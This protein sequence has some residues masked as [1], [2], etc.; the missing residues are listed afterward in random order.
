MFKGIDGPLVL[1]VLDGVGEIKRTIGNAVAL[2]HCPNWDAL[3]QNNRCVTLAAHGR[4]VGLPSD[5]DMGNSEV[6][7]NALGAGQIFD[8]GAKLVEEAIAEGRLWQSPV[9]KKAV[10]QVLSHTS[11]MHFIG[12]LSDGN[13]HSHIQHLLAMLNRC[14]EE[15]VGSARVHVL[16]DGRDVGGTTAH[17]YIQQLEEALQHHRDHGRD[18]AIASGGGRMVITMDRYEA[19]WSMVERGWQLHVLG[20][21]RKFPTAMKALETFREEQPGIIDQNLPGFVVERDG[22]AL[23]P[24]TDGDAVIFFNFR[25]DRSIEISRAFE[26]GD[27]FH[28]FDRGLRPDVFYAGMMQYDGDT[29]TPTNYLVGPPNIQHTLTDFLLEAKVRQFAISETQKFGHITYF[30][31]GNRSGISDANTETFVEIKSDVLPFEQRPWMKAAE[32][33]DELIK[34]LEEGKT[35]F[36]RAN[37]ANGDMVGHTGNLDATI[38]AVACLDLQLG[39][40]MDAV[41]K[42]GGVAIITADHGN[43]DEMFEMSKD[44]N[45]IL[46]ANGHTKAKTSHTLS[47][48]PFVIYDPKSKVPG[49]LGHSSDLGIGNVAATALEILGLPTPKLWLPSLLRP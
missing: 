27:S 13:V 18:Y 20:Q 49:S 32:I 15:K 24:V 38:A 6:G 39:R 16:L 41:R 22:A 36:L 8:Q 25:G 21:G 28:A 31:N 35:R 29:M 43:C 46:D 5:A 12:L 14:A 17:V 44:G 3:R 1:V 30:W 45:A 48:V 23:G 11:A 33:T 10:H 26:E 34:V 47:P 42:A 2:A 7:H 9:W 4:A 40:L 37:Y 19:D